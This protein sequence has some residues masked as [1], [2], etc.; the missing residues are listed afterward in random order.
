MWE[1]SEVRIATVLKLLMREA[2]SPLFVA[3]LIIHHVVLYVF[4]F[5]SVS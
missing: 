1:R 3:V 4:F 2:A 5:M